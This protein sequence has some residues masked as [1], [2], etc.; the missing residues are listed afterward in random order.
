[1]LQGGKT[2]LTLDFNKI[3]INLEAI[4]EKYLYDRLE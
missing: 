4:I 1:M 2:L 3:R